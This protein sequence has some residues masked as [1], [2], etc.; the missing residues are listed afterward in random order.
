MRMI[1]KVPLLLTALTVVLC[2]IACGSA[3]GDDRQPET[4]V[5]PQ[6]QGGE[7]ITETEVVDTISLIITIFNFS[8][9]FQL[10]KIFLTIMFTE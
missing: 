6:T 9:A 8:C 2:L 1:K 5:E 10:V 3:Q 4:S 7:Q